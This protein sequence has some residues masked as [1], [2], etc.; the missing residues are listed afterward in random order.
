VNNFVQLCGGGSLAA[1]AGNAALASIGPIT[2]KTIE[3][4]GGR[5]AV[6]AHPSTIDGLIGAMIEYFSGTK[7]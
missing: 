5:V 2:A 3:E 7:H 4:W 6:M 1:I